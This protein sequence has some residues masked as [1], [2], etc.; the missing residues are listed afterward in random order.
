[1]SED[2]RVVKAYRVKPDE[3]AWLYGKFYKKGAEIYLNGKQAKYPL[4]EYLIE[5]PEKA[6]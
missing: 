6:K 5:E 2:K 3:G 1:M 4:M